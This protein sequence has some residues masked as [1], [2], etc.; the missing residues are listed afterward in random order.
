MLWESKLNAQTVT[1]DK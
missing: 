1:S